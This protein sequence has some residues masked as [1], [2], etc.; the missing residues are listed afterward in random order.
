MNNPKNR[1]VKPVLT[2]EMTWLRRLGIYTIKKVNETT[3][4]KKELLQDIS[5]VKFQE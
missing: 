3:N 5:K 2:V 4:F 1:P